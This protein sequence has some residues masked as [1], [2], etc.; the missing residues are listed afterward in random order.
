[1]DQRIRIVIPTYNER[2]NIRVLIPEIFEV[3][4]RNSLDID[5]LIV[6]DNSP[7]GTGEFAKE[8]SNEYPVNVLE[9]DEKSGL[10]SAY[11]RGFE[12]S[13]NDG[14][15]IIFEMD[16]DMSHKPEYIPSFLEKIEDGFDVV[17][18]ERKDVVGWGLYRRTVSWGGNFIGKIIAGI[19]IDD[20][21]TGYRAY[22]REVLEH[23]DLYSIDSDG[24][25]FQLEI[26]SKVLDENFNVGSV[27]IVFHDRK[28]GKT[29]LS[30]WDILEFF[31]VATKIRLSKLFI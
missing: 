5:I 10:G 19:D 11:I 15:D 2:E 8:L 26:L 23:I 17:M 16:A 7:D 28:R 30:N 13:L 29:K 3:S 24:Y 1:M 21:T 6:D 27:P 22:K 25:A 9:R 4:E 12:E 14:R 20:L 18:G 31:K